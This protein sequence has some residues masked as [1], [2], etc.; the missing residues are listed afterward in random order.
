MLKI[1]GVP[2]IQEKLKKEI[3]VYMNEKLY[4][5]VKISD[6]KDML[7]KTKELYG[8]KEAYKIRDLEN[9]DESKKV[10]KT[11]THKEVREMIDC[12]GTKLIDLGL[13]GKKIGV[14][15]EN[16]F[17]WHIAYLAAV[18]GT[19]VVV[20]FDKSLPENELASLVER[21]EVEAIFYSVKYEECVK[22]VK[23]SGKNNLKYLISF[24]LKESNADKCNSDK[25]GE[26]VLSFNGL[27][28]DGKKLVANGDRRFIDAQI[29]PED[30]SIMLFTS[31]TTA[32]S[33][34]VCLSHRNICSNLMDIASIVYVDYNDVFLSILPIHHVFECTVGFL[35]VLYRG[36]TVVFGDG[37]KY[38]VSNLNEYKVTVMSCVPSLYEG[39]FK[40]LRKQ[41]EKAGKLQNI[42]DNEEK[43]KNLSMEEKRVVF[44]DIHNMLG[45]SLRFLICG[46]AAL[47][48]NVEEK[49]RM[50][51]F[52]LIKGYGLTETSPVLAVE[53]IGEYKT[54][55][56]GRAVPSV[57]A[58]IVNPN[59]EGIGELVV[60]GPNV[61]LGYYKNEEAN[62]DALRD[63][64]FYTGDLARID[65]DGFIFICGRQKSVIVLKNGKN[66]FPEELEKLVD[67]IDGVVES[68]V[69]GKHVSDD[70]N[71]I[72]VH[73]K[74]VFNRDEM[75]AVYGVES[76]EDI[77]KVLSGKVK[78][79]N[80]VMPKY[81]AIRGTIITEKPL[82]K[83]TTNKIKR[84][85]NLDEIEKEGK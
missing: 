50:L 36:A 34:A 59:D 85:A 11:F 47:N 81:K 21:S 71:D 57:E 65:E 10:Y 82:I 70:D 9:S 18:C 54:G 79:L 14:I 48:P 37:L 26:A 66:V 17:E 44:K 32:V 61:M 49:Y 8:D 67:E 64:W 12:L 80:K 3:N 53:R 75:K 45:G 29:N 52:D 83:T 73:V 16:R 24:D 23:N 58:K 13:K 76:D 74:I 84:Q 38:I 7:N 60:R 51:G 43:F 22:N 55:S 35:F 42:L 72:K 27:I 56:V 77:Y 5:I 39:I 78:E 69:Y 19:G 33:K 20:P 46:A 63:G 1:Y 4:D 68:F 40:M 62:K 2:Y 41:L 28:E 6:L 15:G 31:G 30:T 25:C